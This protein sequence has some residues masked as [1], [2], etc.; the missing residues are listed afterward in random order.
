[1]QPV[2]KYKKQINQFPEPYIKEIP[3]KLE[4]HTIVESTHECQ[5]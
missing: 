1:M 2:D 5:E 4:I 3:P